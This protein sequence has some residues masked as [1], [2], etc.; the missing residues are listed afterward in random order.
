MITPLDIQN[1][2]F[3]TKI[4]GYSKEEVDKFIDD[5]GENYQKIYR[6][7]IDLKDKISLLNESVQHY[8]KIEDT[9]HNTLII[10]EKTADETRKNAY[11]KAENIIRE[12]EHRA[13]EIIQNENEKIIE[14]KRELENL[15][16]EYEVFKS[17]FKNLIACQMDL[18][19]RI[20]ITSTDSQMIKDD[21]VKNNFDEE[22]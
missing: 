13:S 3:T 5:L 1:R 6:E 14:K 2:S 16:Q 22:Q 4:K 9:L 20:D 7:N 21:S 12:A 19:E 10:A 15:K 17:K 18:I 11:E 8:R